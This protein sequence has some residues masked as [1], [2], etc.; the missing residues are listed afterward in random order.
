MAP[1]PAVSNVQLA[2][3]DRVLFYTDGLIE[4]R[5][6]DGHWIELDETL[7]GSVGSDPLYDA[8][9]QLL[10]RLEERVGTLQDDI[11]LLLVECI[12]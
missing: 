9:G 5:D 12:P 7:L 3:G 4:S 8:L 2:P 11:A 1:D 10:S 6:R